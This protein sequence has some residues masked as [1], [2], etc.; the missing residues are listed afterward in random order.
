MFLLD[1]CS[2]VDRNGDIHSMYYKKKCTPEK[3]SCNFEKI[4]KH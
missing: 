1:D 4:T 3:W 2:S